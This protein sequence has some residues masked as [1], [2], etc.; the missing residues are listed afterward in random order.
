MQLNQRVAVLCNDLPVFPTAVREYRIEHSPF[1]GWRPAFELLVGSL[2]QLE[3][4]I[5]SSM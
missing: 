5:P 1:L 3:H 4:L 2:R